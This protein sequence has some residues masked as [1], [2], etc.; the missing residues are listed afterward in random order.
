MYFMEKLSLYYEEYRRKERI[1]AEMDTEDPRMQQWRG[2]FEEGSE[3]CKRRFL[4]E[5]LMMYP[6]IV[7]YV[8]TVQ[9]RKLELED[10]LHEEKQKTWALT[11]ALNGIK[12]QQH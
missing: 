9:L 5:A 2:D 12:P 4:Q 7:E 1:V 6:Q 10:L 11:D 3:R 8:K